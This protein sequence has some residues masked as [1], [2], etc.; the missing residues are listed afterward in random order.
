MMLLTA[1]IKLQGYQVIEVGIFSWKKPIHP[2]QALFI[3][4][5]LFRF[6]RYHGNAGYK[7]LSFQPEK[8]MD[9]LNLHTARCQCNNKE[10]STEIY[11]DEKTHLIKHFIWTIQQLPSVQ[12]AVSFVACTKESRATEELPT[13]T[14]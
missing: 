4:K 2:G 8:K 1:S 11:E 5:G 6:C 13:Q 7:M 3:K 10:N 14:N 12:K 9:L